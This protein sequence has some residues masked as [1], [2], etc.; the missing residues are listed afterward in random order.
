MWGQVLR[1][2]RLAEQ[3]NWDQAGILLTPFLKDPAHPFISD[4]G[5]AIQ[6]RGPLPHLSGLPIESF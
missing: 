1:S 5:T 3:G 2:Y 4:L 6:D